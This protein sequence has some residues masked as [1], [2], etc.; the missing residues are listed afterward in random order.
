[1]Q[2][3]GRLSHSKMHG[4][5]RHNPSG[6]ALSLEDLRV[7]DVHDKGNTTV[8]GHMHPPVLLACRTGRRQEPTY[9]NAGAS[10]LSSSGDP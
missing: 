2:I 7:F 10:I 6:A 9:G 3:L 8:I 5:S 1:M 4:R